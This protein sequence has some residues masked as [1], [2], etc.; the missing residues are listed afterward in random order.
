[1]K[2]SRSSTPSTGY[3]SKGQSGLQSKFQDSQGYTEK[4]CLEK[5]MIIII[6][7]II[8]IIPATVINEYLNEKKRHIDM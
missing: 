1:M 2:Y 5:M 8:I 3:S 6:I 7:I 4:L